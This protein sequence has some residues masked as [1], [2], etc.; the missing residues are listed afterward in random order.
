MKNT[1]TV[2]YSICVFASG[3]SIATACALTAALNSC[4]GGKN[5]GATVNIERT[6]LGSS[7]AVLA[8]ATNIAS[9]LIFIIT[10]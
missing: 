6:H 4:L 3:T 1:H 5:L 2:V 9:S 10:I 7:T 8:I